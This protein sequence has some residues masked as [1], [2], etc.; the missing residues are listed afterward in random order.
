MEKKEFSCK[1]W[2]LLKGDPVWSACHG[3]ETPCPEPVLREHEATLWFFSDNLE[4]SIG[5]KA[6]VYFLSIGAFGLVCIHWVE[7]T[8]QKCH[9]QSHGDVSLNAILSWWYELSM[10][11]FSLIQ[12]RRMSMPNKNYFLR[13]TYLD[14]LSSD[15]NILHRT[16]AQRG[17]S[18]TFFMSH[19]YWRNLGGK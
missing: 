5:G 13:R 2:L 1:I 4:I 8:L 3:M 10:C 6:W 12:G 7:Y 15:L 17:W 19:N 14:W 11:W 18:R 16:I 9:F